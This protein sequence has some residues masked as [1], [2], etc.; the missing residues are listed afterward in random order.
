MGKIVKR[1]N[2]HSQQINRIVFVS[3][4]SPRSL[5]GH[6]YTRYLGD[7]SGGQVLKRITKT[8]L[9]VGDGALKFYDFPKISKPGLYKSE[10]RTMLDA[11]LLSQADK[12]MIVQ[13]ANTAFTMNIHLFNE[14]GSR[15]R[16]N[17]F[18]L[19]FDR[20]LSVFR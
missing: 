15:S 14:L 8:T 6:H 20:V 7:L 5:I 18:S 19:V 12:E 13:E 11:L 16:K 3:E 9:K 2:Q 17:M 1:L 4:Y 10:Y